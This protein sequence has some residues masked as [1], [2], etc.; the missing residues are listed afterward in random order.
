MKE[1]LRVD[2]GKNKV[3]EETNYLYFSEPLFPNGKYMVRI[4][5]SIQSSLN[6]CLYG[7]G[8]LCLYGYDQLSSAPSGD[9]MIDFLESIRPV[10][11]LKS[12]AFICGIKYLDMSDNL[13]FIE[14]YLNLDL[15]GPSMTLIVT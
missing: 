14:T 11:H 6:T 7:C 5:A 2:T 8:Q 12:L 13:S 1:I 15:P 4:L 9:Q 10:R 3:E